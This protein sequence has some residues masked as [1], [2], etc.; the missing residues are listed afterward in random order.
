MEMGG[1]KRP[2]P[3]TMGLQNSRDHSHGGT[4]AIGA[5]HMNNWEFPV[6]VPQSSEQFFDPA[7]AKIKTEL[8]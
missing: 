6:G 7:Q 8:G 1:R 4:F 5:P 3:V 2:R